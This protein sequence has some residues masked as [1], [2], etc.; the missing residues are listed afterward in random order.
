MSISRDIFRIMIWFALALVIIIPSS[1]ELLEG[2]YGW[3][4]ILGL[5]IGIV[6]ILM[7][8]NHIFLLLKFFKDKEN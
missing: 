4:P 6:G 3:A 5:V 7:G 8:I 1:L 2:N